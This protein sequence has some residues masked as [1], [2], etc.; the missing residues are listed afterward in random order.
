M[1]PYLLW[2]FFDFN[3]SRRIWLPN[4]QNFPLPKTA[5]GSAEYDYKACINFPII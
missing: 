3:G 5:G 2:G 4:I 1:V